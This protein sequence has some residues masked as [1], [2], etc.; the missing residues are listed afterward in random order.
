M[1]TAKE[2]LKGYA[3]LMEK[4]MEGHRQNIT[5]TMY[6]WVLRHGEEF[7]PTVLNPDWLELGPPKYCY[8]NAHDACAMKKELQYVEGFVFIRALPIPLPHAWVTLPVEGT[9][10]CA[11]DV[12]IPN[13]RDL[14]YYGVRFQPAYRRKMFR[15]GLKNDCLALIDNWTEGWPLMQAT[16]EELSK[17]LITRLDDTK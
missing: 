14:A 16:P 2:L 9:V 1:T 6:S 3:D 4:A 10:P 11:L 13:T 5:E 8:S 17:I 15:R 7:A 12:T